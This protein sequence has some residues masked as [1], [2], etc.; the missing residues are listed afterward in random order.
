MDRKFELTQETKI[1]SGV[2]LYR[3]KATKEFSGIKNGELG[4]FVEKEENLSQSDDAWV[5]GNAQVS[6]NAL[7]SGDARVSDD[8]RVFGNAWMLDNA[9]VLG[10]ARVSGNARVCGDA[11]VLGYE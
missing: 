2:T 4:G 8:A 1:F 11:R 3:I 10:T 6:G 7:V 9:L 5:F